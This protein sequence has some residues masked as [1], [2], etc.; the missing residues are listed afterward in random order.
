MIDNTVSPYSSV[1]QIGDPQL[2]VLTAIG[3]GEDLP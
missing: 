1:N 3:K 2:G